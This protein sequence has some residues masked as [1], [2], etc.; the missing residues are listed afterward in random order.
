MYRSLREKIPR[1]AVVAAII[2]QVPLQILGFMSDRWPTSPGE[3]AQFIITGI[4]LL[5]PISIVVIW[6][7]SEVLLWIYIKL[8]RLS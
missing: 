4:A 2:L 5:L 1:V 7:V 8:R 3:T 6:V